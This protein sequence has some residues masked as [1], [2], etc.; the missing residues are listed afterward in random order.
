[1]VMQSSFTCWPIRGLVTSSLAAALV[2]TAA[3]ASHAQAWRSDLPPAT[4]SPAQ[5]A[6]STKAAVPPPRPAN[7]APNAQASSDIQ[8]LFLVRTT[9]MALNDANRTGNYTVLRDIAGPSF[10]ERNSAADLGVIFV[11]LRRTRLDL[12]VAALMQPVFD[13]APTLDSERRLRLKG[14]YATEPNRILF[15]LVFEA[16]A[17]NWQLFGITISTTPSRTAAAPAR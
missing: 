6:R 10:R 9:L 14:G 4:G 16:V 7:P 1:M 3:S 11:E 5:P 12:S 15:D 8:S 13:G 17:G 2:V